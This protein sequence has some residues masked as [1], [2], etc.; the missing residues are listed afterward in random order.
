[1]AI[2]D[3]DRRTMIETLAADMRGHADLVYDLAQQVEDEAGLN[4]VNQAGVDAYRAQH[5]QGD[6]AMA[7]RR[8]AYANTLRAELAATPLDDENIA[9]LMEQEAELRDLANALGDRYGQVAGRHS[10]A[11]YWNEAGIGLGC[12]RSPMLRAGGEFYRPRLSRVE[13]AW[14]MARGETQYAADLIA[15]QPDNGRDGCRSQARHGLMVTASSL[16][17][18]ASNC[19]VHAGML[20]DL[21]AGKVWSIG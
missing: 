8:R 6:A 19:R 14:R 16:R 18:H 1:M 15:R 21:A 3:T 2:S 11:S 5:E 4:P 10:R 20:D 13:H 9:S 17:V 7:A 12:N